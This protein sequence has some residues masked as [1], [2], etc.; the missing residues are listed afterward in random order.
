[1][2]RRRPVNCPAVTAHSATDP[3]SDWSG[4]ICFWK[5]NVEC[6]RIHNIEPKENVPL[7]CTDA[8]VM[9][10]VNYVAVC[11]SESDIRFYDL[12][13]M[14]DI[15]LSVSRPMGRGAPVD[16]CHYCS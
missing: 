1:M 11:S 13:S 15:L 5:S 2:V 4:T 10:N 6:I 16:I 12:S 7:Y 3:N 14:Y 9:N 8:V